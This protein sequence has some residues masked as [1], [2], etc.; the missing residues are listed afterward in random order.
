MLLSN[1][2]LTGPMGTGK[3][4]IGKLLSKKLNC[5]FYDIDNE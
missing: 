2:V 3:S 1:V 4:T 5:K